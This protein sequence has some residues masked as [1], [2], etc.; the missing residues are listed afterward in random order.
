ML[1]RKIVAQKFIHQYSLEVDGSYSLPEHS[2]EQVQHENIGEHDIDSQQYGDNPGI[3]GAS[4]ERPC[5]VDG[6]VVCT[7]DLTCNHGKWKYWI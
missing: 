2:D 5:F 3:L 6:R 1:W 4:R 7:R